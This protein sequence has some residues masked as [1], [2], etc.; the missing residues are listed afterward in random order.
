MERISFL[1]VGSGYRAELY[2]RVAAAHPALFRAAFLCRSEEKARRMQALF[3]AETFLSAEDAAKARPA[4]AVIAVDKAHIAD[5][6]AEW[7]ERGFPVLLETPA[8]ASDAQAA[9]L[10]RLSEA[11]C[12]I[13]VSEQYP[14]YP[15]LMAGLSAI[16]SGRIGTPQSAYLSLVHDYHAFALLRRMLQTKG[17]RVTLRAA[18]GTSPLVRTDARE[19]AVW[20][21]SLMEEKRVLMILDYASGKR[22]ICDFSGAQYHTY[23]RTRHVIVR[24]DR[25]EW[26]DGR[27]LCLNGAGEPE[28]TLLPFA[29]PERFR[30]LDTQ[31]FRDLRRS[32]G[33]TL[34]MET[35]E[36]E[37]AVGTVL[38]DMGAFAAGGAP[39][40]ALEEALEDAALWRLSLRAMES[41]FGSFRLQGG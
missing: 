5:V 34:G 41:P 29:F 23:L 17:E 11:G 37:F 4:F 19:G 14:R 20:D 10:R 21:G 12:R 33:G 36:D 32:P 24:G 39:P 3:G 30:A 6:G 38:M 26:C 27:L 15:R 16:G 7:A 2:G 18:L 13:A 25:G 35:A 31:A 1:V 8:A 28:Q 9:R 40:C 22:A